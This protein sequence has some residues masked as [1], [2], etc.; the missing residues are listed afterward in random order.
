MI[1]SNKMCPTSVRLCA[2]PTGLDLRWRLILSRQVGC[3]SDPIPAF[4]STTNERPGSQ[5]SPSGRRARRLLCCCLSGWHNVAVKECG[6]CQASVW[7]CAGGTCVICCELTHLLKGGSENR[8]CIHMAQ[9]LCM[10]RPQLKT[11]TLF[12]LAQRGMSMLESAGWHLAGEN[13][14]NKDRNKIKAK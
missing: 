2:A 1:P 10:E 12:Y 9:D 6:V 11:Q 7:V 14:K 4:I 13:K 5:R 3:H 8:H